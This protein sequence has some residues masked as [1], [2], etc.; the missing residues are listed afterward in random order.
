MMID[1]EFVKYGKTERFKPEAM[2]ITITEKIDGTNGQIIINEDNIIVGSRNRVITPENDNYGFARWVY[3]NEEEIR[4]LGIGRHYGEWWGEGIQKN[5]YNAE[6]NH[7]S[8]FNTRRPA[9]TLPDIVKQVP[10]L[11]TG[12]YDYHIIMDEFEALR[13]LSVLGG[14]NPEGIIIEFHMTGKRYKMTYDYR[15][16]KWGEK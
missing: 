15:E 2:N 9:D 1:R 16:G 14:H 6:G 12:I 4:K 13:P 8:I 3:D 11:Y 5:R 10:I 7:F